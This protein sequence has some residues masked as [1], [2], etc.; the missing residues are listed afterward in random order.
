MQTMKSFLK[1]AITLSLLYTQTVSGQIKNARTQTVKI[2]G[3]CEMCKESIE[4]AANKKNKV[5]ITWNKDT[6]L[7]TL[8][9]DSTRTSA[10]DILRQVA[11]AG[12]DNEIFFAPDDAYEKLPSCCKYERTKNNSVKINTGSSESVAA[13]QTNT[14]AALPENQLQ[15]IFDSYIEL[16]NALIQSS[17]NQV[18]L[19]AKL[20]SN[21]ISQLKMEDL[22]SAQHNVWMN[23]Y[24][25]LITTADD[26][27]QTTDI[28][29]QRMY[30]AKLSENMHGIIAV[31]KLKT[32]VYYQHCPM[33]NDGKGANWLSTESTVKNPYYGSQMLNCGKTIETIK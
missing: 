2:S 9:Y 10:N 28:E 31:A 1:F 6:K 23:V 4:N 11:Y 17:T 30:F 33:Y 3:N 14:A 5:S 25:A 32:P 29:Q 15:S 8:L 19:K 16:K 22:E 27:S 7:A 18:S 12:Y 20:L 24:K 21:A 13:K 26:I